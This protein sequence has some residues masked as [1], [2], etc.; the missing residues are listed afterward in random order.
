[1][2]SQTPARAWFLT[3][4]FALLI[5]PSREP[6]A[7]FHMLSS[8]RPAG[9]VVSSDGT[10]FEEPELVPQLPEPPKQPNAIPNEGSLEIS[11]ESRTDSSETAWARL[12]RLRTQLIRWVHQARY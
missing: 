11:A 6:E 3:A 5:L 9:P 7:A 4:T 12:T 1:M 2:K 10:P 8:H